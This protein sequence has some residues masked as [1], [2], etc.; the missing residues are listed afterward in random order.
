MAENSKGMTG[1]VVAIVVSII[2]AL[3]ALAILLFIFTKLMGGLS[4]AIAEIMFD[5][6]CSFCEK[7]GIFSKI[8][9]MCRSC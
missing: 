3:L 8:G 6:K 9:R 1:N 4:S 2:I 7:V 5:L